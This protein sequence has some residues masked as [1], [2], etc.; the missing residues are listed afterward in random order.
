MLPPVLPESVDPEVL[1]LD[2]PSDEDPLE[3]LSLEPVEP[4]LS[5]LPVEELLSEDPPEVEPLALPK[6]PTRL[7][8][9]PTFDAT[10]VNCALLFEPRWLML[11]I[12]TSVTAP[13]TTA[14]CTAVAPRRD[15][16]FFCKQ[17]EFIPISFSVKTYGIRNTS[18]PTSD[19]RFC[20]VTKGTNNSTCALAGREISHRWPL[21]RITSNCHQRPDRM[22]WRWSKLVC[23]FA[24]VFAHLAK[25]T[26]DELRQGIDG[27][28]RIGTARKQ[29]ELRAV[30]GA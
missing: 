25:A 9:L 4:L 18:V 2:D 8:G 7:S 10:C 27:F 30:A 13:S 12:T 20:R 28:S 17:F 5:E 14:I 11:P 6:L 3:E 1:P 23:R 15:A 22:S 24:A 21:M 16:H 29:I 26:F 19:R